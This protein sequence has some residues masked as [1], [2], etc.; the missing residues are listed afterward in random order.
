M[1]IY[2]IEDENG[3]YF[4]T[5]RQ[6][7]FIRL[8][9]QAG[10]NFLRT[11]KG[12]GRRFYRTSTK[13]DNGDAVFIEI[14]KPKEKEVRKSERHEQ[15][16]SDCEEEYGKPVISM[17]EPSKSNEKL[18]VEET[19]MTDGESVEDRAIHNMDIETL[20]IAFKSLTNEE[21]AIVNMLFFSKNKVTEAQIAELFG[22][23]TSA[24]SQRK[25]SIIK[26][27]RKFFKN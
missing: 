5:D 1:S 17:H 2:Y 3:Q 23:S 8:T 18:T 16:V 14:P 21:F 7:R 25:K 11:E 6:R 15:Y 10:L 20:H 26:K 13:E 22:V 27:L 24:I 12:K 4:S 9:G 19:E